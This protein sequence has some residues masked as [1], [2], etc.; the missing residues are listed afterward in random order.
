MAS[1]CPNN[2]VILSIYL[3]LPFRISRVSIALRLVSFFIV[4]LL[5]IIVCVYLLFFSLT[6][7][8]KAGVLKRWGKYRTKNK[9]AIFTFLSVLSVRND[10]TDVDGNFTGR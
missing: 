8:K 9:S 2:K 1:Y 3:L 10:W 7:L 6:D 5:G 4:L